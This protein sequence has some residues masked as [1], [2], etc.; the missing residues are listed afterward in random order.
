M[1][2]FLL[3]AAL[4]GWSGAVFA[5]TQAEEEAGDVSEVDKDDQGPLRE[6]IRPVSGHVFLKKGRFELSPGLT[7]SFTDAFYTKYIPGLAVAFHPWETVGF[8]LRA[9]Y[10]IPVISGAAQICDEISCR[11]PTQAQLSG[12][13]P[14]QLSLLGGLEMQWSPIYGKLSVISES[15]LHFDMYGIAGG[16]FIQ[17]V[18]RSN[19]SASTFGGNLGLGFRIVVNRWMAVRAELRDLIYVEQYELGTNQL[20][21][22]LLFDLGFSFFLPSTFEEENR[23]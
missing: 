23:R 22:Q 8:A 17:Y 2:R 9:G 3:M 4:L 1:K 20:R 21:N 15:F 14:G 12:R 13:V 11:P 16:Q 6:R 19:A 18:G 10:S 5:Q 7:L